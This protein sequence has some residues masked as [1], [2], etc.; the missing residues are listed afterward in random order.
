M[1]SEELEEKIRTSW[2]ASIPECYR[3]D[4][5][6]RGDYGAIVLRPPPAAVM[7]KWLANTAMHIREMRRPVEK[8]R[9]P[10]RFDDDYILAR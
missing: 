4:V 1:I 10:A 5:L 3:A 9:N 2:F 6:H 7:E 8:G